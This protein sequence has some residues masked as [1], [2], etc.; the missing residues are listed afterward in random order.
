MYSIEASSITKYLSC[1]LEKNLWNWFFFEQI[2]GSTGTVHVIHVHILFFKKYK[3][4]LPVYVYVNPST[5]V[6]INLDY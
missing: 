5:W 6:A 3:T 2:K 1:A 4:S